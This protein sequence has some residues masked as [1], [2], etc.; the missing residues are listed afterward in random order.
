MNNVARRR[1]APP[2]PAFVG[3]ATT[4]QV[5]TPT[6][7]QQV[8]MDAK[9]YPNPLRPIGSG[10]ATTRCVTASGG[11]QMDLSTMNRVL[12]IERDTVTVQP[13]ISLPEL[14][15]VLSEE[16]LELVGGF[17]LANRTVGGA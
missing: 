9:R 15:E 10:S 8:L 17:D 1:I 14:A 12:K 11:T 16:G 7:I 4:I 2:P 6:E 13:G 5:T 3:P